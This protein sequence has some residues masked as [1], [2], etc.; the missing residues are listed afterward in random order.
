MP[1]RYQMTVLEK[2]IPDVLM[3][4]SYVVQQIGTKHSDACW[5]H[6]FYT[7]SCN[8]PLLCLFPSTF[9]FFISGNIACLV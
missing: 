9:L 5:A 7:G 1:L 6:K 2:Y 4:L 3:Y 8:V